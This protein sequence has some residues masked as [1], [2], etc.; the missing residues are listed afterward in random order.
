M[1]LR[2]PP[3][4]Q[5]EGQKGLLAS[6]LAVNLG[7]AWVLEAKWEPLHPAQMHFGRSGGEVLMLCCPN[8]G[9]LNSFP[10]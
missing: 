6:Y 7:M 10:C 9:S 1:G 2:D 3:P 8:I 4:T 5:R